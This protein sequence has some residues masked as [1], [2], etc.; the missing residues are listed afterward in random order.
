MKKLIFI[1]LALIA[2][3]TIS[4]TEDFSDPKALSGTNWRCSSFSDASMTAEYDYVEL[5]F[6]STT[7]VEGWQKAKNGSVTK[8]GTAATYSIT[9]KTITINTGDSENLVGVIDNKTMTFV[10]GG[11]TLKFT[12]Q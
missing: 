8:S 11:E 2:M 6:V 3:M 5:R 4:C 10:S 12:K 9:D 1:T 7:S